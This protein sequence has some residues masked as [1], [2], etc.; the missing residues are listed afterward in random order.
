MPFLLA[1]GLLPLL[2]FSFI[3]GLKQVSS[4]ECRKPPTAL[5]LHP[6]AHHLR[7]FA[8]S[9]E[10]LQTILLIQINSLSISVFMAR[11]QCQLIRDAPTLCEPK[12]KF[13]SFIEREIKDKK[14]I[15]C[16]VVVDCYQKEVETLQRK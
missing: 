12:K 9:Q 2:Y 1:F 4:S 11:D 15:V 13:G 6:L 16:K 10:N 3:L 8:M 7:S 14:K 5:G